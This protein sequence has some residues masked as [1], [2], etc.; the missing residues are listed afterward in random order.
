MNK[1][2]KL[3]VAQ[4]SCADAY[5][6]LEVAEAGVNH[7]NAAYNRVIAELDKEREARE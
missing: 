1:P 6:A 2:S 7:A 4:R 3:D 5:D